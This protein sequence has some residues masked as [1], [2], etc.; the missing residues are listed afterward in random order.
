M[1]LAQVKD[2]VTV[3]VEAIEDSDHRLRLNEMGITK[4]C[5]ITPAYKGISGRIRAYM[6]KGCV[7]AIRKADAEKIWVRGS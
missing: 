1:R 6:V 2:G 3:S 5:K 4:G 7:L